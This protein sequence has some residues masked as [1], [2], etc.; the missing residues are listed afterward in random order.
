M[1]VMRKVSKHFD[2]L[3]ELIS[4]TGGGVGVEIGSFSGESMLVFMESNLVKKLYC[5]DPFITAGPKKYL[6][7][8]NIVD[9]DKEIK[10][11]E[12]LFNQRAKK[13]GDKVVKIKKYASDAIKDIPAKVDFVYID[14]LHTY[15]GC[16]SD[17]KDYYGIVKPGGWLCGHDYCERWPGVIKAVDEFAK[18]K[19]VKTF[20]DTSWAVML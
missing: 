10:S 16:K 8:N 15:E 3:K 14:G 12:A 1:Y 9:V 18:G 2:G 6:R 20:Q 11:V 4:T 17:I 19:E 5:V 13:Y 7:E